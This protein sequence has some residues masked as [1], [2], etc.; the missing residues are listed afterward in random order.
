M[1]AL[2]S[3]WILLFFFISGALWNPV[4]GLPALSEYGSNQDPSSV[5]EQEES[6][7]PARLRVASRGRKNKAAWKASVSPSLLPARSDPFGAAPSSRRDTTSPRD[8][9]HLSPPLRI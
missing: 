6:A 3:L 7:R 4:A 9:Q 5:E 1:K 2:G 8:V